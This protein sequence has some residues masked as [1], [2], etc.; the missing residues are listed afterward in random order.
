[1]ASMTTG[2]YSMRQYIFG[3]LLTAFAGLGYSQENLEL[4]ETGGTGSTVVL[5]KLG[6]G[7]LSARFNLPAYRCAG[8]ASEVDIKYQNII[9]SI[10]EKS[11]CMGSC[12]ILIEPNPPRFAT[13]CPNVLRN[14]PIMIE[15]RVAGYFDNGPQLS[16]FLSQKDLYTQVEVP[17]SRQEKIKACDDPNRFR[18]NPNGTI[19]DSVTGTIWNRCTIGQRWV[20]SKC[21]PGNA[22]P[23]SWENAMRSAKVARGP[24]GSAGRIPSPQELTD[25]LSSLSVCH[26]SA[27]TLTS[28][29]TAIGQGPTPVESLWTSKSGYSGNEYSASISLDS[30]AVLM[31]QSSAAA[32]LAFGGKPDYQREYDEIFD[33]ELLQPYRK[34]FETAGSSESI[35]AFLSRYQSWDP[36]NLTPRAKNALNLALQRERQER[37]QWERDRSARELR[38]ASTQEDGGDFRLVGDNYTAK[39][40]KR[41]IWGHCNNGTLFTGSK[42]NFDNYWTVSA[43]ALVSESGLTMDGAVRKACR[44]N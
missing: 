13:T 1:M 42:W 11:S 10:D 37:E 9:I 15:R 35:R 24:N 44:G 41:E 36:E 20:G 21:V 8:D 6:G 26:G 23:M 39:G 34:L 4:R 14:G 43:K 32:L 17:A 16:N 22:Q 25:Y 29:R 38:R 12:T 5:N 27:A 33:E 2:K 28:Y 40:E 18:T 31:S 3:A 19:L 30:I 7:K